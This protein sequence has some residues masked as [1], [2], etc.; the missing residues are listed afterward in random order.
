[1]ISYIEVHSLARSWN[2]YSKD[3]WIVKDRSEPR[4]LREEGI[5]KASAVEG[6]LDMLGQDAQ[7]NKIL[8]MCEPT[9]ILGIERALNAAFPALSIARSSDILLEIMQKGVTK[10][11]AIARLCGLWDIPLEA[12][13][14]FGDHYNDVEMLRAVGLPFLMGNAPNELKKQFSN[15]A[16]DNDQEGIYNALLQAGL[17]ASGKEI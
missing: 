6:T 4:V 13:V 11:R 5:V 2:I 7:V 8:C 14:A 12:A 15:I 17:I 10:G 1:M 3:T 9:Q 16:L